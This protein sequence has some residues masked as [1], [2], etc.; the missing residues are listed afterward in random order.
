MAWTDKTPEGFGASVT[1][2]AGGSTIFVTNLNNSGAGSFREAIMGGSG[3]RGPRIVKFSVS[4]T[5][6]LT[7]LIEIEN[8]VPG[9]GDNYDDLTIDASDAPNQGVQTAGEGV[10]IRVDNVIVKHMRFRTN[11][12]GGSS[13][14]SLA[15]DGGTNVLISHCS[16]QVGDDGDLDIINGADNVTVQYCMIGPNCGSGSYLN[17][18]GSAGTQRVSFHHNL[19]FN[20][21]R[22]PEAGGPNKLDFV[23]NVVYFNAAGGFEAVSRFPPDEGIISANLVGNYYKYGQ[24]VTYNSNNRPIYFYSDRAF[25][26]S[27]S[28]YLATNIIV[29]DNGT[30]VTSTQSNIYGNDAVTING[31]PFSYPAITTTTAAQAYIDVLA[32]AGARQPCGLDALDQVIMG[33]L[34]AGTGATSIPY[35]SITDGSLGGY[36]DLTVPC[37]AGPSAR[38]GWLGPL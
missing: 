19:L 32:F 13:I 6:N 30:L 34:Q 36:P 38:V 10:R 37:P 20:N 35:T 8:G 4:G 26:G 5:I 21:G 22:N 16:V 12:L 9:G 2:G 1:G 14:D 15:V 28:F 29:D 7:S 33:Q 3:T 18:Y 25:S 17:K 24:G 27:S 11:Q 31:S 23:N